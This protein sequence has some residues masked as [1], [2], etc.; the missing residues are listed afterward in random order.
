VRRLGDERDTAAV[1]SRGPRQALLEGF[2]NVVP[3]E[4]RI[5]MRISNLNST[6]LFACK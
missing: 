6:D 4:T 3:T 2:E 1:M 5:Q